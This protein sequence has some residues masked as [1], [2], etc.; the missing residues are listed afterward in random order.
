[1]QTFNTGVTFLVIFRIWRVEFASVHFRLPPYRVVV[2][3]FTISPFLNLFIISSSTPIIICVVVSLS[4]C[5]RRHCLCRR[6]PSQRCPRAFQNTLIVVDGQ[7]RQHKII[8]HR[9]IRERAV[10]RKLPMGKKNV[11]RFGALTKSRYLRPH[12]HGVFKYFNYVYIRKK[13]WRGGH[14]RYSH[15][16]EYAEENRID[17]LFFPFSIIL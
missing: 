7:H 13:D 11:M 4:L 17:R 1:M 16:S 10:R 14:I 9:H 5:C 12:T 15:Y 2:H 8:G 3:I 6:R